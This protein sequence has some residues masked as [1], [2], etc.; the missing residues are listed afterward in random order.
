[1]A[2]LGNPAKSAKG[3]LASHATWGKTPGFEP[4]A[5]SVSQGYCGFD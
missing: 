4:W 3:V 5:T 2:S 1:M